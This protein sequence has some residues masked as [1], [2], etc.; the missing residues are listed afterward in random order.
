MRCF[1]KT[2]YTEKPTRQL[3]GCIHSTNLS[4]RVIPG[5]LISCRPLHCPRIICSANDTMHY[6]GKFLYVALH[7][8]H[9]TTA[10][11]S[12]DDCTQVIRRLHPSHTTTAHKSYDDCTQVIRR[13]HPSHTTTAHKSY[14]DCTQSYDD[15]T[16]VIRRL[17]PNHTKTAP[18]SYDDCTQVIRRLHPSHTTTAPKSYDDCTQVIRR[19]HPS[20][21]TTAPKSYDDCT[22]VIRRLHPSHTTTASKSYDTW[23]SIWQSSLTVRNLNSCLLSEALAMRQLILNDYFHTN[24]HHCLW[25]WNGSHPSVNWINSV[26]MNLFEV[27]YQS[28]RFEPKLSR[29]KVEYSRS[30][31]TALQKLQLPST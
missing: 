7:P 27:R 17:H 5:D 6:R 15:C 10:S 30:C 31:A 13:L 28:T 8:S 9:T 25:P 24:I 2:I 3:A 12:Y 23:S 26:C 19:L 29:L 14:D 20:H 22:Q 21:T 18:K 1:K 11:K 4:V 16:Q